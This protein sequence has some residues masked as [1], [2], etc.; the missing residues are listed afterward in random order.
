MTRVKI[1]EFHGGGWWIQYFDTM[2]AA[3][4]EAI[5]MIENTRLGFDSIWIWRGTKHIGT[6][7]KNRYGSGYMYNFK[8]INM[9]GTIKR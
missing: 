5:K 4:K 9:N 7:E 3:R 1:Q 8:P 2:D 6:V